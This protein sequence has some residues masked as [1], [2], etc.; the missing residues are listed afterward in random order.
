MLSIPWLKPED[1][2]TILLKAYNRLVFK[3]SI[4]LI[5]I[6]LFIF[7]PKQNRRITIY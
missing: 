5:I 4:N 6:K 3:F 2:R 1:F 7:R